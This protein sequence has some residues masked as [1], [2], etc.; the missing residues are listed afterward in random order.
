MPQWCQ[1]MLGLRSDVSTHKISESP[2]ANFTHCFE[3]ALN[4]KTEERV[5]S[6]QEIL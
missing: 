1:N 5:F 2:K 3:H 6:F 4:L